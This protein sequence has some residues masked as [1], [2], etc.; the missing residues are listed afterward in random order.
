MTVPASLQQI[1]GKQV[2]PITPV[3]GDDPN[4]SAEHRLMVPLIDDRGKLQVILPASHLLDIDRLNQSL[5]RQFRAFP[6]RE[7]QQLL[8]RLKMTRL[9]AVP[10]LTGYD[11]VVD[12]GMDNGRPVLIDAGADDR[13]LLIGAADFQRLCAGAQRLS[14]AVPLSRIPVNDKDPELDREQFRLAIQRFTKLRISQRLEDTLELPPLPETAQRIIHLRVN[15]NAEVGDLT[16]IVE[17]DPSL[18]AQ[19]VS[20]ASSSFY[21]APGRVQSVYDAIMRV[22]GFDL[23]MNLAMG[24]ALG[25]TLQ[26]PKDAPEGF[27]D[28]WH[29]AIWMAQSAGIITGLMPRGSRPSFGLAYLSGLLHNFGYLVLAHV[30]PPHFSLICRYTEANAH[31]DTRYVEQHL[32]GVTREQIGSQLMDIW[33][34]P[35]EVVLALRHQK[36]P[37]YRGPCEAYAHVLWLARH[38]LAERGV[39]VGPRTTLPEGFLEHLGLNA[40]ELAQEFDELVANSGDIAAMAGMMQG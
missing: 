19:V 18:A 24:L 8:T 23:V 5:N 36:N 22:L 13:Q 40:G 38:L 32:I 34:M 37:D 9:P 6:R 28:Y 11:T 39:P 35:E 7:L 15:P 2:P 27:L 14:V 3:P 29:Q 21:A 30:F 12:Q 10:P 4:S 20:W 31:L 26:Q 16:D 1:L 17:S 33:A 25:R